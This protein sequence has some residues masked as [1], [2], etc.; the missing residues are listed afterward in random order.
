[1][2]FLAFLCSPFEKAAI[3]TVDGAG[4]AEYNSI[5]GGGGDKN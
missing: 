3:L 5:M 2:R 1:M 4:E